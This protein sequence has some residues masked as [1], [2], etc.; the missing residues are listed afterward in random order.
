MGNVNVF[1]VRFCCENLR[2]SSPKIKHTNMPKVN[3]DGERPVMAGGMI[4]LSQTGGNT[5]FVSFPSGVE[6][7]EAE[8][9]AS[10][11]EYLEMVGHW[12]ES[13]WD[14]LTK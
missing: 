10:A 2:V 6:H 9:S 7:S 12:E 3:Y 11:A 4:F 14:F 1:F 8:G 13:H 5:Y